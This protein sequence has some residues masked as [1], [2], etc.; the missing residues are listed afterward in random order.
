MVEL[1]IRGRI[2]LEKQSMR[3]KGLLYRKVSL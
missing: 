1:A 3:R 2:E